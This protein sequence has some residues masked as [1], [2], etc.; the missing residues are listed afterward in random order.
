MNQTDVSFHQ[1]G[2][3]RFGIGGGELA[4]QRYVIVHHHLYMAAELEF[5]QSIFEN[6]TAKTP[7]R[8]GIDL[9]FLVS[10]RFDQAVSDGAY[11]SCLER[12]GE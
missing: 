6:Q 9:L 8:G 11:L 7:R 10:W 1:R 12:A 2:K 4:H 5:G 3:G